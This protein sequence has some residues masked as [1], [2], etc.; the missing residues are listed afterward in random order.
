MPKLKRRKPMQGRTID[1]PQ[2]VYGQLLR[3]ARDE[4]RSVS[5]LVRIIVIA[6]LARRAERIGQEQE[7]A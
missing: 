3:A 6:W 4:E 1:F 5:Q 7:A 2:D